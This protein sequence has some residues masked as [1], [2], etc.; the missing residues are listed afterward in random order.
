MLSHENVGWRRELV[1]GEEGPI[2]VFDN[3]GLTTSNS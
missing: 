1:V 3:L 2:G